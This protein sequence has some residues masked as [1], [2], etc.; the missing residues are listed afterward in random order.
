MFSTRN[1]VRKFRGTKKVDGKRWGPFVL[2]IN[3]SIRCRPLPGAE[4]FI[5]DFVADPLA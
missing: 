4:Q 5:A 2:N 3:K 1:A